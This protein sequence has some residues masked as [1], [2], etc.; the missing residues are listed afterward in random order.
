MRWVS[1]AEAKKMP[2]LRA[3]LAKGAWGVWSEC[4]KG[5][6]H[7]KKIP[8]A[9]V[10]QIL[11]DDNAEIVAWTGVRNQPQIVFEAEPVRTGWL[12][13]LNLAERLAPEPSLLPKDPAQ[14]ALVVGLANELCGEWGIGWCT[15]LAMLRPGSAPGKTEQ[16]MR[17]EYGMT[18]VDEADAATRRI[19]DI[20]SMLGRRLRDQQARGS[21][22][23]VG[24]D[25]S[26]IDI[27]WACF[28]NLVQPLPHDLCPMSD[29]VRAGFT[30]LGQ[31][32]GPAKDPILFDHR[33]H[34]YRTSLQL[35]VDFG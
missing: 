12:D 32:I 16:I 29:E 4:A 3:V 30:R 19:A 17:S 18:D 1:V 7:Y 2:G 22:Y 11:F 34:V 26:A 9:A 24:E 27:Y 14:R 25:V 6:L 31:K 28:S 35:P 33:D 5:L 20:V 23:F 21:R 10:P 15:R 13:I 8:Y